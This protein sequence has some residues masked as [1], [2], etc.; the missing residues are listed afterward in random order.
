MQVQIFTKCNLTT[1]A[2]NKNKLQHH[3]PVN[4]HSTQPGSVFHFLY[5]NSQC[6]EGLRVGGGVKTN[7]FLPFHFSAALA[8]APSAVV[9][10]QRQIRDEI[11]ET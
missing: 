2:D 1:S 5:L 11:R 8:L 6:H 7:P 10:W 9:L 3:I 4:R